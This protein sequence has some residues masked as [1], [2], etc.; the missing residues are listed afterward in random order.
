MTIE[1]YDSP[2][3]AYTRDSACATDTIHYTDLSTLAPGPSFIEFWDWDFG[4]GS[5]LVTDT[6]PDNSYPNPGVFTTT[7]VVTTNF[8][9]TD[10]IQGAVTIYPKPVADFIFTPD[11]GTILN[12]FI[13]FFDQTVSNSIGTWF[14]DFGDSASSLLANPVHEYMDTGTYTIMLAVADTNKCKDTTF[15]EVK[16]LPEYIFFAPNTFTPN[17]DGFNETFLPQGKGISEKGYQFYIFNRW[18]DVIWKTTYFN[19]PWE[20]YA[21]T[22][23][24]LA[25]TDVYVWLILS[26][27]LTGVQHHYTGHV[28]LFR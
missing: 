17:G 24:K 22:G 25:Q 3:A 11:S 7:L 10:T 27:D 28:T 23:N 12:P 16:V 5:D 26:R 1:V 21:N 2:I 6:N 15:G 13:S 18:G 19:V 14:W 4:D 9:C 20:G 8:G